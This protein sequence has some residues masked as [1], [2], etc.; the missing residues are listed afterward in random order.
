MQGLFQRFGLTLEA[1]RKDAMILQS[2]F[3]DGCDY[4]ILEDQ[5]STTKM[6][7]EEYLTKKAR[8]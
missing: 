3:V 2:G 4:T 7:I 8:S 5:W 1:V 6:K